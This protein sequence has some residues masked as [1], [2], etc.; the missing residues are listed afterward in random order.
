VDQAVDSVRTRRDSAGVTRTGIFLS[1]PGGLPMPVDLRL[2]FADGTTENVRLPVEAWYGGSRFLYVRQ[3]RSDLYYRLKVFPISLPPLRERREDIPLLV[4]YFVDKHARR[5]NRRIESIP[6]DVMQALTRW[7]WPGNIRE[8][9][10]FIERAVILS[11]GPSLRVSLAEL[12]AS[13]EVGA[14][15]PSLEAANREHILRL[16]RETKGMIGGPRGA[17]ARLGLKRT[18]LSSKLK[19]LG[20]KREDY[21]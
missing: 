20:I 2:G 21:I 14:D 11:K 6:P 8:L 1:S 19:K 17:A 16:L 9:E 13:E 4:R 10:N 5:M 15:D 3:F 7:H 18:T 12:Q